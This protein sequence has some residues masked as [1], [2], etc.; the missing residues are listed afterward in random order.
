MVYLIIYFFMLHLFFSVNFKD[1]GR[2]VNAVFLLFH[3]WFCFLFPFVF[4]CYFSFFH[5]QY[6]FLCLFGFLFSLTSKS[7]LISI[8][9]L[10]IFYYYFVFQF[11]SYFF[12]FFSTLL[13]FCFIPLSVPLVLFST[14]SLVHVF[15]HIYIFFFQ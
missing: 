9:F 11:V 10:P 12:F 2:N 15:Y 5:F 6:L 8:N 3:S 1:L 4:L 7:F 14:F 13:K